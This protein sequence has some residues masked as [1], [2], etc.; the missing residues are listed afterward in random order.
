MKWKLDISY[1]EKYLWQ[2]MLI[3]QIRK[4]NGQP[5]NVFWKNFWVIYYF[6]QKIDRKQ[7]YIKVLPPHHSSYDPKKLLIEMDHHQLKGL[8][9]LDFNNQ[10]GG[11]PLGTIFMDHT[12]LF[13]DSFHWQHSLPKLMLYLLPICN[14][15]FCFQV[16]R[17]EFCRGH[18]K[19]ECFP[20]IK[21]H[22]AVVQ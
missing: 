18:Q 9:P 1:F 10:K 22:Q 17:S 6:I 14:T 20:V 11:P 19:F 21:E 5:R 13:F 3:C 15:D 12:V 16:F 8:P 7:F 4:L 2:I